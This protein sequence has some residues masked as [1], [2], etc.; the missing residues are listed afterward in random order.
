LL[1]RLYNWTMGLAAHPG[2]LWALTLVAFAESS[3]FPI[4]PDVLLIPMV[5]AARRRAWLIAAVCTA[6][7]VAGGLAGYGIGY[8]L[9]DAIGRPLVDLFGGGHAF[10]LF[11]ANYNEWGLWI[12][13][14][15]GLTPLP[16][17]VF[18]ILSGVTQLDLGLFTLGSGISRGLRFFLEVLLL[19]YVG[20]PIR[21]FVEGNLKV[22]TT[23]FVV[24]LLGSFLVLRYIV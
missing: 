20:E 21:A 5:L 17:K 10:E 19:W 9:Y 18:T 14:T 12:V 1:T 8:F 3:F 22:V 11:R 4:P 16:Y 15:A 7:S 13:F 2:A 23:V 24:L 6:A